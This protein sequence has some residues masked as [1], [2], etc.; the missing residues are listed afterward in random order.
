MSKMV[1][2]I[3]KYFDSVTEWMM[4]LNRGHGSRCRCELCEQVRQDL[5]AW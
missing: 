5:N 2:R 3:V 4:E 1:K